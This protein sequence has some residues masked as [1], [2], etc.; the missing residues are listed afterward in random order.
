MAK[1]P[2][3]RRAYKN[4]GRARRRVARVPRAAISNS[5]GQFSFTR[6]YTLSTS[7]GQVA[8]G[9]GQGGKLNA[10]IAVGNCKIGGANRFFEDTDQVSTSAASTCAMFPSQ[11]LNLSNL[12]STAKIVKHEIQLIPI[13]GATAMNSVPVLVTFDRFGTDLAQTTTQ[14]SLSKVLTGYLSNSPGSKILTPSH[15]KMPVI[16]RTYYPLKS[17]IADN[18][19]FLLPVSFGNG[20]NVAGGCLDTA[21]GSTQGGRTLGFFKIFASDC[22]SK[23]AGGTNY[24]ATEVYRVI[25]RITLICMNRRADTAHTVVA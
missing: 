15:E 24:V 7:A 12:Y 11:M 6:T 10:V 4:R 3:R 13:C 8:A 17:N 5:M 23:D 9:Q 20:V 21:T 14:S 19:Q 22:G 16:T 2:A 18:S 1:K 25:E